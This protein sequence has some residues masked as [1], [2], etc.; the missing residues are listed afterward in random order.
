MSR[1]VQPFAVVIVLFGAMA[2]SGQDSWQKIAPVGHTFSVMMPTRATSVSQEIPSADASFPAYFYSATSK[3]KR[4][5]AAGFYKTASEVTPLLSSF[6][7]FV[8]AIEYGLKHSQTIKSVK[9]GRDLSSGKLNVKQ[10][11]FQ[12]GTY[13]GIARLIGAQTGFYALVFV[14]TDAQDWDADRFFSSFRVGELNTDASASGADP[15]SSMLGAMA[16]KKPTAETPDADQPGRK[17][18][19]TLAEESTGP[20]PAPGSPPEPWTDTDGLIRG[21]VINGRAISLPQPKYPSAARKTRDEGQVKVQIVI[22]ELGKVSKAEVVEGP[23]SI[24][25]R[26]AAVNAAQ[27]SLFTPT[28]LMGQPVKVSGV[29]IYNFVAQ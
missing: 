4:F 1:R 25:L 20:P 27:N 21:G 2:A 5:M 17:G 29:L 24:L 14:G 28:F 16:P 22:D 9:Q 19:V 10:Y 11:D 18:V 23:P 8:A 3:D 6:E 13:F 7:N 15:R 26:Y 12:I